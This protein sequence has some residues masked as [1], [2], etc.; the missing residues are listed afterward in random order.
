M[1]KQK[2]KKKENIWKTGTIVLAIVI[3]LLI[4]WN[5]TIKQQ[6]ENENEAERLCGLIQA[7]PAWVDEYGEI[8]GY[9]YIASE[10]MSVDIVNE[11]L[12]PQRIKFLYNSDCSACEKQIEYFGLTWSDY[13]QSGLTINCKEI[14]E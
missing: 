11:Y 12:I 3:V 14:L 2:P 6:I 4:I 1:N 9:G 7:T 5:L 8:K 10:N 13:Q